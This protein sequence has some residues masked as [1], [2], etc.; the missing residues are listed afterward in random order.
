MKNINFTAREGWL[1]LEG[2]VERERERERETSSLVLS[3]K[4]RKLGRK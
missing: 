1:N 3:I 4:S 2:R